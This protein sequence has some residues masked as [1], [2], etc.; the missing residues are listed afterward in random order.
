[1]STKVKIENKNT[2]ILELQS[3]ITETKNSPETPNRFEQAKEKNQKT[4][5]DEQTLHEPKSGEGEKKRKLERNMG[6]N[7]MHEQTRKWSTYW[8]ER[9]E[10]NRK[11]IQGNNNQKTSQMY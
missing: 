7:E 10:R 2:I 9:G 4:W 1:M 8:K 3:T 11:N 5:I 6:H